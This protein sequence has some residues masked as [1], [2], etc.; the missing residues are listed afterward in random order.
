[1][2]LSFHVSHHLRRSACPERYS[3]S[4]VRQAERVYCRSKTLGMTW[5]SHALEPF[6]GTSLFVIPL[7]HAAMVVVRKQRKVPPE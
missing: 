6:V 4:A 3:S 2:Q 1:L 5:R 7:A